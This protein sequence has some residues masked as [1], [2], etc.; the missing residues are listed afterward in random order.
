MYHRFCGR[1]LTKSSVG[2]GVVALLANEFTIAAFLSS[3]GILERQ[4]VLVIRGLQA[5]LLAI[6]I[7]FLIGEQE[8]GRL[9]G[10]LSRHVEAGENTNLQRTEQ[11]R[12]LVLCLLVPWLVLLLAIE[13]T[14][15]AGI[16][17]WWLWPL[18]V[19]VLAGLVTDVWKRVNM[20]RLVCGIGQAALAFIL[21]AN[22]VLLSRADSWHKEGWSGQDSEES[23]VAE[24]VASQ[25]HAAGRDQAAIGYDTYFSSFM[26]RFNIIDHRY[27]VG[28]DFDLL[29][30]SREGIQNLDCCA[31]GLSPNDEF[32]IVQ[33]K[34]LEARPTRFRG[35]QATHFNLAVEKN[36]HLL[37]KFNTYQV[38][39]HN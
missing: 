13:S 32:L 26:V 16:R 23:Q 29:F 12:Y 37:R 7:V 14:A 18:Q 27:K 33:T 15:T 38:F 9:F 28:A 24:Y 20:P 8:V 22:P 36:F 10:R 4:T 30:K 21:L 3:D 25:V 31:Q 5:L 2:L 39:K 34:P 17:S 19:I 1:Y 11:R 35:P 6:A